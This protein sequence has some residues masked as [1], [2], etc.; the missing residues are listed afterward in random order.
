MS[1]VVRIWSTDPGSDQGL[2]AYY[3]QSTS[4]LN[5]EDGPED[6]EETPG[7]VRREDPDA[8]IQEIA[9][10]LDTAP[11]PQIVISVH[12]FNND[13]PDA[14]ARL[15]AQYALVLQDPR[16][17]KGNGLV[18]IGYRWPSEK[19]GAPLATAIRAMPGV[20]S[21]ILLIATLTALLGLGA[22]A[23]VRHAALR[24]VICGLLVLAA[25]LGVG[26]GL[27]CSAP[28]RWITC[29]VTLALVGLGLGLR[30]DLGGLLMGAQVLLRAL[31]LILFTLP[32]TLFLLRV[33]VYFRDV[34]RAANYGVPDLV[35]V[36]RNLHKAV[37]ERRRAREEQPSEGPQPPPNLI[38][39]SFIGHSM[40]AFVVTS[41]IRILSDVFDPS[42]I[43][44]LAGIG[45]EEP[46]AGE[47]GTVF[48]LERLVLVSPDIPAEAI[49]MRRAN[50]LASAL[51]RFR[52]AY[53]FSNEGDVVLRMISTMANY[54]S[55]PN[56]MREHG[57][58]LG[59]MEVVG[60][61]Y[62]IVPLEQR[63]TAGS[64][65]AF[66][67][68][69]R[70]GPLDLEKQYAALTS[71]GSATV[72]TIRHDG[73]NLTVPEVFTYFDCTEYTDITVELDEE[74]RP[75]VGKRPL[76]LLT[77]AKRKDRLSP[78]DNWGLLASYLFG[79]GGHV[80]V[81]S[82]YF[83]GQYVP[84]LIYRL[85]C[86]GFRAI[87]PPPLARERTTEGHSSAEPGAGTDVYDPLVALSKECAARR[88]RVL[89]SP[90]WL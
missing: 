73:K 55:F 13:V 71:T 15:Q 42:T 17:E 81:H 4:P 12:G 74:G 80:D 69:L 33:V 40:G 88:L 83:Q 86:V 60:T 63:Y 1:E 44:P 29:T 36:L 27:R 11:D 56:T 79:F 16:I 26:V 47:I 35:E 23:G 50:F 48:S 75:R 25:V 37:E 89:L 68:M 52:E 59:N 20:L 14:E 30:A 64:G 22:W 53:L 82:G 67:R 72:T 8:V 65:A 24:P 45:N 6:V 28:I 58:R 34:Y 90:K 19:M 49:M 41:A 18:C 61:D 9:T 87:L 51:R 43:R 66:L 77:R 7:W 57:F 38:K 3:I 85:A 10:Y 39:L 32:F 84:Q 76:P 62:G 78:W 46:L 70:V 2:P 31:G 21:G 5:V 54:F